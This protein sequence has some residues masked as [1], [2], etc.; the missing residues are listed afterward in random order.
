[1]TAKRTKPK[2]LTVNVQNRSQLR[3]WANYWG[4]TQQDVRDAARSTGGMVEDV[5]DWIKINVVR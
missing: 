5:D 4:C 1:M 3:A 2:E